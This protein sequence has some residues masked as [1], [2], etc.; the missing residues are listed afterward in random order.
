MTWHN[1]TPTH[2]LPTLPCIDTYPK[3]RN[4]SSKDFTL[5]PTRYPPFTSHCSSNFTLLCFS[6]LFHVWRKEINNALLDPCARPLGENHSIWERIPLPQ[7][8]PR[9]V[10][11]LP[12]CTLSTKLTR[13]QVHGSKCLVPDCASSAWRSP[14][15]LSLLFAT[16]LP[17]AIMNQTGWSSSA[18][19]LRWYGIMIM[20]SACHLWWTPS[21]NVHL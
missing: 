18:M 15:V 13:I 7:R 5:N 11:R 6:P 16:N 2:T 19:P 1:F 3:Q 8:L 4:G 12:F 20:V 21:A 9:Q 17:K 10:R 14:T